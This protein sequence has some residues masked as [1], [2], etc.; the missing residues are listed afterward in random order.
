VILCV[1]QAG[2]VCGDSVD[3]IEDKPTGSVRISF[4]F[5]STLDDARHFIRFVY[6]CF[7]DNADKTVPNSVVDNV[8]S[9]ADTVSSV[10]DTVSRVADTVSSV[11][12]SRSRSVADRVSVRVSHG[13][14]ELAVD[15]MKSATTTHADGDADKEVCKDTASGSLLV[16]TDTLQ[17][18]KMFIYPVKS[19]AGVEVN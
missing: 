5:S 8:S 2:H 4:G 16:S 17:L 6:E 10:A 7:L 12:F 1:C 19:C 13:D 3:L 15:S 11:A 14:S 9:V 18:V